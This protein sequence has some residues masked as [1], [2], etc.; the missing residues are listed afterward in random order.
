MTEARK[1]WRASA[2]KSYA[3]ST[4]PAYAL[5]FRGQADP[6][7]EEFQRLASAVFDPLMAHVEKKAPGK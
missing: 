7:G 2:Y 4:D 5:A 6:L 3:E 1:E